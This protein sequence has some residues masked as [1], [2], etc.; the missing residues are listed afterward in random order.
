VRVICATFAAIL[1]SVLIANGQTTGATVQGTITDSTMA[2][3][4]GVKVTV[5]NRNTKAS[6]STISDD[7]GSYAISGLSEGNYS[8][9]ASLQ[10]FITLDVS[11]PIAKDSK[12][13]QDFVLK[14]GNAT[15]HVIV[16]EDGPQADGMVI[17]PQGNFR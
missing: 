1:L 11:R 13:L 14:V 8:I 7:K 12:T 17:H 10:G 3:I 9:A 2:L 15:R 5:T 6:Y 4:P 16:S